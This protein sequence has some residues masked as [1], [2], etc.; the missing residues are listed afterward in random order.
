MKS[1]KWLQS[2]VGETLSISVCC[3]DSTNGQ[4]NGRC[5]GFEISAVIPEY[6]TAELDFMPETIPG[7]RFS[8]DHDTKTIR[9]CRVT[10]PFTGYEAWFGN[11]CWDRFTVKTADL[12]RL[13][14][15]K[16]FRE[17]FSIDTGDERLW[18]AWDTA[19]SSSK[20]P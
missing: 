9:L 6:G 18:T 20:T 11:W 13:L 17:R 1:P 15:S 7:L 19:N 12:E 3:N 14:T 10:I 8:V 5:E 4:F 16:G 2:I